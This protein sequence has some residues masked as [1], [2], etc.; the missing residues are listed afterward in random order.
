MI[1]DGSNILRLNKERDA[2]E[3]EQNKEFAATGKRNMEK[4]SV[5]KNWGQ[6]ARVRKSAWDEDFKRTRFTEHGT[7]AL[8]EYS[9]K[10]RQLKVCLALE[11]YNN[12]SSGSVM[13]GVTGE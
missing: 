12:F 1:N 2:R 8:R 9:I 11:E 3:V 4:L 7:E 6:V 13:G 5:A 10:A